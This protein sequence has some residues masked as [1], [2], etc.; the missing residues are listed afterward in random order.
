MDDSDTEKEMLW[1]YIGSCG[2]RGFSSSNSFFK[3][4]S[5]SPVIFFNFLYFFVFSIR[6]GLSVSP[7]IRQTIVSPSLSLFLSS[8]IPFDY[9]ASKELVLSYV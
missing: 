1:D 5:T 4:S 9:F 7:E 2:L 3:F 8:R 6:K